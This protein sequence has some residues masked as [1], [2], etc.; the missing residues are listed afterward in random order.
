MGKTDVDI[1]EN[2]LLEVMQF[3]FDHT[4]FD[5]DSELDQEV[6]AAY[7]PLG[8]GPGKAYDPE[9]VE[10]LD[11]QRF[12]EVAERIEAEEMAK[13][14]RL[15][16]ST[17]LFQLKGDIGLDL[18]LFQSVFG[19]IGQPAAEAVYPALTTTDG[20]P[21]NAQHDYVIRMSKDEMPPAKAFWSVTLYDT[22][23]GFF[24]P[25]D[26]KKYSVG[27]NGGHEARTRT[28]ASRSSSP[29]RSPRACP[30]KTGCRSSAATTTSTSSCAL[31]VAG[32][33]EVP[34]LG[35]AEGGETQSRR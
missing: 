11:G 27:E 32:P 18:L 17:G 15:A 5:P 10:K 1:F 8:V 24:I 29:P 6:L 20:A 35:P 22:E 21:M 30:R 14:D 31:Y 25:N 16:A 33:G 4:T 19:P 12:R 9:R 23:N 2:N 26:R 13:A 28:A 3:V 34:E 7:E